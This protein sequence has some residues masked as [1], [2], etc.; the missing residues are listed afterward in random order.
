ML[1]VKPVTDAA[2]SQYGKIVTGFDTADLLA[3]LNK[4]PTPDEVVYVP[5]VP[6]FEQLPIMRELSEVFYGQMP[7]QMGYCNG[8][9]HRLDALEYHRDSELNLA[10]TD[11]ILLLA[12]EQDIDPATLT[13]DTAK[14][15]AFFVPQGTM[16]ETYATTLHYAPVSAGGKF[17]WLVVLPRGTNLDLPGKPQSA[18]PESKLLWASNKWLLAHAESKEAAQGAHVGLVGQNWTL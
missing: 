8:D 4:T 3:A 12:R 9:N 16:V 6:E 1:K 13:L 11:L 2:F 10:A 7:I 14:V 5:T 15:E 17:R 18:N